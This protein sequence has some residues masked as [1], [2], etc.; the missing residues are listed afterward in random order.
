MKWLHV[1]GICGRTTSNVALMFKKMGWFVT[2]SDSQFFSPALDVLLNNNIPYAEGYNYIHLS[3]EFWL[4]DSNFKDYIISN[5]NVDSVSNIPDLCLVVESITAKNKELLFAKNKGIEILPFSKVLQKY[6]VKKESVVI[7]GSAGKTTTTALFVLAL[8]K[9]GIN[10]SYMIGAEVNGLE[11]SLMN[12]DSIWSV[13]EGDEFYNPEISGNPKFMFFNPKYLVITNIGWEHQDIYKTQQDYVQSFV[14]LVKIV[15][16]NG[17]ILSKYSQNTKIL[18]ELSPNNLSFFDFKNGN[19]NSEYILDIQNPENIL[20]IEVKN[21]RL[22][23]FSVNKKDIKLIGKFNYLNYLSLF[24]FLRETHFM[25]IFDWEICKDVFLQIIREFKGAKKRLEILYQNNNLIVVDDF[26]VTPSRAK[27]TLEIL[28]ENFSDF[29]LC[30]VFEPNS[31]S[32]TLNLDTLHDMYKDAFIYSNFIIIP[33]LSKPVSEPLIDANSLSELLKS[34]G[35]NAIFCETDKLEKFLLDLVLQY[36]KSG[37]KL[38]I[39]FSSSYRLN[40]LTKSFVKNL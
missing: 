2:G 37:R 22:F 40:D 5:F 1:I 12:T 36:K 30:V 3:K 4:N 27:I 18:K 13:I 19:Y 39:V 28:K 14:N 20:F 8:Q 23:K 33:N 16:K 24:A 31:G 32:R 11:E 21:N 7:V 38:L 26:G 34:F 15:P 10:P 6:L 9:L 25:Q 35:Y 29:D 17:L